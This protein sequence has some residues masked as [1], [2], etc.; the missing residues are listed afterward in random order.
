[1]SQWSVIN[2]Q[3]FGYE[4][5]WLSEKNFRE[6]KIETAEKH[7]QGS[8]LFYGRRIRVKAALSEKLIT[9]H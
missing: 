6:W 4:G 3:P 1:M 9:D 7:K 2:Q 5:L 8:P